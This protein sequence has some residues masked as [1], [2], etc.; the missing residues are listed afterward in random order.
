MGYI[1]HIP[2]PPGRPPCSCPGKQHLPR[3]GHPRP[4][5]SPG[6]VPGSAAPGREGLRPRSPRAAAP[7]PAPL[8]WRWVRGSGRRCS[9][10]PRRPHKEQE[11]AAASA[12]PRLSAGPSARRRRRWW[13]RRRGESPGPR[14]GKGWS[15]ALLLRGMRGAA[16]PPLRRGWPRAGGRRGTAASPGSPGARGARWGPREGRARP[17]FAVALLRRF[18]LQPLPPSR[19][20]TAVRFYLPCS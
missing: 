20:C 16:S 1:L 19:S 9:D 6:W 17:G 12:L 15:R 10:A 5:C 3:Q 13:R 7:T 2:A 8:T 18:G 14:R 11:M 4:R